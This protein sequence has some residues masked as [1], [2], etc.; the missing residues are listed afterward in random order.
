TTFELDSNR[1]LRYY[2]QTPKAPKPQPIPQTPT[3]SE[4]INTTKGLQT[5]QVQKPRIDEDN[6]LGITLTKED[7]S[8][9]L[10]KFW[11]KVSEWF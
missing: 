5:Q 9:G 6:G 8:Q 2:K 3:K 1:K 7:K 4:P 11:T 10:S